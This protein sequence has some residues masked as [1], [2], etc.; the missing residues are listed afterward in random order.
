MK[1]KSD[2]VNNHVDI[3]HYGDEQTEDTIVGYKNEGFDN[4]EVAN[5]E[6]HMETRI[7][8]MDTIEEKVQ[9]SVGDKNQEN[10]LGNQD[11]GKDVFD[12]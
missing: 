5:E 11:A 4:D 7:E 6:D 1:D 2:V 8:I 10:R 3:P 12:N 9:V